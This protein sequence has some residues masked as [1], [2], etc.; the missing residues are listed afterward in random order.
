MNKKFFNYFYFVRKM[1]FTI[2]EK[3]PTYV[4]FKYFFRFRN[5]NKIFFGFYYF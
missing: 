3:N 2:L 1:F 4:S 5:E